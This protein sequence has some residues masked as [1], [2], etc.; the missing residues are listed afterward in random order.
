MSWFYLPEGEGASTEVFCSDTL[1]YA[2]SRLTHAAETCCL[3]DSE[4]AHFP[5]S[6]SGMTCEPSTSDLGADTS[7]SSQADSPAKTSA[8]QERN[9]GW[10]ERGLACGTRWLGLLGGFDPDTH[11]L[12]TSQLSLREDLAESSPTLPRWGSM[13]NGVLW[14]RDMPVLSNGVTDSGFS[15]MPTPTRY[16]NNN[17]PKKGTK[18]GWGLAAWGKS[19]FKTVTASDAKGRSGEGHIARHGPKR[20]SDVIL[21]P[22]G[23]QQ[24]PRGRLNPEWVE[25]LMGLPIGAT[26]LQPLE[27]HKF[28]EWLR[29]H[30]NYSNDS[31]A[32]A[33]KEKRDE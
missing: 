15:L 13:R 6:R 3:P 28:R 31:G 4:T 21:P 25:W 24:S 29:W 22:R 8:Q 17:R 18:R 32:D 12:R 10:P 26:A 30:G 33:P 2:P 1:P 7:M 19:F 27:T 23:E 11:S 20:L 9:A 5:D 16:G 14:E